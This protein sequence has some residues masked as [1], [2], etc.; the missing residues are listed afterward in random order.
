MLRVSVKRVENKPSWLHPSDSLGIMGES[1][2]K[3]A[4]LIAD[5]TTN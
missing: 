3:L 5:K 1:N 4:D 2:Q